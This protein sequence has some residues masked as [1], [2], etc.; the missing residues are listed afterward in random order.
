[1]ELKEETKMPKPPYIWY[2]ISIAATILA[3]IIFVC[4]IR[5]MQHEL[6]LP[7]RVIAAVTPTPKPC[8]ATVTTG[9]VRLIVHG[10][11]TTQS[12]DN[13][14]TDWIVNQNSTKADPVWRTP[15][16]TETALRAKIRF[17]SIDHK[18]KL[19]QKLRT[20]VLTKQ[21]FDEAL[22]YGD[23]LNIEDETVFYPKDKRDDLDAAF[24]QQARLRAAAGK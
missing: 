1:L 8:K 10:T 4:G 18:R 2:L 11:T 21:E 7:V 16:T 9:T 23:S 13:T 22:S 6:A 14:S 15:S 3:A 5:N 12:W 17:E 24:L 19:F 20:Q